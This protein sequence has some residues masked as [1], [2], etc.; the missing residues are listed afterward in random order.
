MT[1]Q[2]QLEFPAA[3]LPPVSS[4]VCQCELVG[5]IRPCCRDG[6]FPPYNPIPCP[7]SAEKLVGAAS[8]LR[9]SKPRNKFY[10][11]DCHET[12]V[13]REGIK[14]PACRKKARQEEL[15]QI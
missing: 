6:M 12:H 8:S 11:S 2:A 10:C 4:K 15:C 14:C 9:P 13:S 5:H 1:N 3:M 7:W